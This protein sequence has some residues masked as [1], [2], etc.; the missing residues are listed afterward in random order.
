[1]LRRQTPNELSARRIFAQILKES[2]FQTL[3]VVLVEIFHG[4]GPAQRF[5]PKHFQLLFEVG[6]HL[7]GRIFWF[8]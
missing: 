3:D 6:K 2:M 8:P 1:M 5:F 4:D 7:L